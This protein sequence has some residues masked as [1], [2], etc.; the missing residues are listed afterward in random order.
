MIK[1]RWTTNDEA[2]LIK[3]LEMNVKKHEIAKALAR[4]YN[5]VTNKINELK[6]AGITPKHSSLEKKVV[7]DNL[8]RERK[9]ISTPELIEEIRFPKP[10]SNKK[11]SLTGELFGQKFKISINQLPKFIKIMGELN[12]FIETPVVINLKIK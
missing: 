10:T 4:T 5:A 9:V 7:L 11:S 1:R 3:L 2:R 6:D 12:K 8:G